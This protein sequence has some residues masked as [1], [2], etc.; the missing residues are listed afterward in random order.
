MLRFVTYLLFLVA[1]VA[2]T[3]LKFDPN[4]SSTGSLSLTHY[5]CSDGGNGLINAWSPSVN[6]VNDLKSKLKDGVIIAAFNTIG[7]WNSPN[8]GLCYQFRSLSNGKVVKFI[9]VDVAGSGTGIVGP[10]E[11]SLFSKSGTTAEGFI[12]VN[13]APLKAT[14]CYKQLP[15]GRA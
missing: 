7:G 10:A 12:P 4:Y 5:A 1:A 9:A 3:T 14:E 15:R 13:A 2:A 8:C 6:T 11:F